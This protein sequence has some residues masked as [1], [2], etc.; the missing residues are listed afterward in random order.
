M[1]GILVLYTYSTDNLHMFGI[2]VF[3]TYSTDNL[4]MFGK[5]VL[6]MTSSPTTNDSVNFSLSVAAAGDSKPPKY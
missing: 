3:Y 2:Q 6:G 4:D 1:F 5:L